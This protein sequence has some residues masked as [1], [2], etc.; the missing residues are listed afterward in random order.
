ML[1]FW[2]PD[3]SLI[4]NIMIDTSPWLLCSSLTFSSTGLSVSPF[5]DF[6]FFTAL[7]LASAKRSIQHNPHIMIP[8][9]S[10]PSMTSMIFTHCCFLSIVC[11][12]G[13]WINCLLLSIVL[14]FSGLPTVAQCSIP[15]W[16]FLPLARCCSGGRQVH[17]NT[18]LTFWKTMKKNLNTKTK[19][20]Q[21]KASPIKHTISNFPTNCLFPSL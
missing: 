13:C 17:Q 6:C 5:R 12:P 8:F 10:W 3:D 9:S 15:R 21:R 11:A 2:N 14:I 16:H 4:Q 7:V 19:L 1:Y 20:L 18:Q